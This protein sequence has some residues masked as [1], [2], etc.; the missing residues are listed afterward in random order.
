MPH[1]EVNDIKIYYEVHGTGEPLLLIEGLGYATWMWYRQLEEFSRDFRVI[2]FDNRGVGKSD[3]PDIPYSIEMMAADAA[4]LLRALDIQQAHVLGVSMGGF[5]AQALAIGYPELVH[6]LILVC[7][8]HGGR[9]AIPAPPET[10]KA[11]LNEE[12]L[13][14]REALRQAMR[15]AFGP[16]YLAQHPEELEKIIEWRLAEPTPRY[17]WQRQFNAILGADLEGKLSEIQAPTLILTGDADRVVPMANSERLHKAIADSVLEVFPGGGHLFF[18]EQ[19][20][21]FNRRV[22]EFLK[23]HPMDN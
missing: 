11:M 15:P 20:P 14:P 4:G 3:K 9:R 2:I 12:G 21:A 10:I 17:A 7:T 6:T 18:L 22:L 5:I 13:P 16:G 8:S 23:G 19:A 1:V